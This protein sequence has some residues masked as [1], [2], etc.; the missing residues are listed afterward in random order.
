M[1]TLFLKE[2]PEYLS[3]VAEIL[4]NQWG[5]K[6]PGSRLEETMV[7]LERFLN[8]DQIPFNLICLKEQKLIATCNVMLSD[9]P[10][11]TDVSP[12][13]GSLYVKPHFRNKG[14]GSTLVRHAV[15]ISKTLKISKI[16][17]CTP[18]KQRMYRRLGWSCIDEVEYRGEIVMV[19]KITT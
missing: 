19:M 14:I 15:N 10:A 7:K 9:P 3:E 4:F 6:T 12:W 11:R 17:L 1:K 13:F 18:D 16:Y 2:R 5:I 8:D